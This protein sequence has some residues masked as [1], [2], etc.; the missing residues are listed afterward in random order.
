MATN[1]KFCGICNRELDVPADPRSLDCGGHCLQCMAD[2]GDP[3][4]LAA[5]EVIEQR[6]G[7]MP[8]PCTD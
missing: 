3:D 8:S 2:A 6:V 5:V 7:V 1:D 4:C